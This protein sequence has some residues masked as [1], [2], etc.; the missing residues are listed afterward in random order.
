MGVIIEEINQ[1]PNFKFYENE[2]CSGTPISS[3]SSSSKIVMLMNNYQQNLEYRDSPSYKI[4]ISM[5]RRY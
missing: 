3:P 5:F 2:D 4:S 1:K